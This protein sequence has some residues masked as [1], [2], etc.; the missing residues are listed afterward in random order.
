M[1]LEKVAEAGC[2]ST[3]CSWPSCIVWYWGR[4]AQLKVSSCTLALKHSPRLNLGRGGFE[5]P[6]GK[7]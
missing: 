6:E 4:E 7:D 1:V 2:S 5:K 3:H